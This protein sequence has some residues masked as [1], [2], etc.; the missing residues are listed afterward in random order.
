MIDIS[1]FTFDVASVN[2]D[3]RTDFIAKVPAELSDRQALLEALRRELQLPLYFGNNW[4]A[5]SECLRDLSWIKCRRVV[6]LHEDLPPL[7][8]K[9]SATYLGVLSECVRD[10]KPVEDHELVVAFPPEA[11]DAMAIITS[12]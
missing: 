3:P 10:W 5:L 2:L 9:D 7:N 11:R 1:V 6:I 8:A 12:T 4:D